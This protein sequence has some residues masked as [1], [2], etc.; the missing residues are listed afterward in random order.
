[1][2]L[3]IHQYLD[4]LQK[5]GAFEQT[6]FREQRRFNPCSPARRRRA[7]IA[8]CLSLL[9]TFY[10]LAPQYPQPPPVENADTVASEDSGFVD[11]VGLGDVGGEGRWE[12]A[13]VEGFFAQSLDSTDDKTFNFVLPPL[14]TN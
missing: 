12:Y 5:R 4:K 8:A 6:A 3:H 13:V 9:L 14:L 10:V 11:E 1:M 7:L 2:T